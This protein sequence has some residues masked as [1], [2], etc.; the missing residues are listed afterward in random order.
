MADSWRIF[1]DNSYRILNHIGS[2]VSIWLEL[3]WAKIK[4]GHL[5]RLDLSQVEPTRE[6]EPI[7]NQADNQADNRA[8]NQTDN[9]ADNRMDNHIAEPIGWTKMHD[10]FKSLLP[11]YFLK[12]IYVK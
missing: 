4:P 10:V 5:Y 11:R 12:D 3:S 8:D 2:N 7:L 1:L 9:R 6:L